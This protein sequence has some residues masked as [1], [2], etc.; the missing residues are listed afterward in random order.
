MEYLYRYSVEIN[1]HTHRF[2]SKKPNQK[3]AVFEFMNGWQLWKSSSS[4][5]HLKNDRDW[6]I[7][8]R[9]KANPNAAENFALVPVEYHPR[10]E[11]LFLWPSVWVGYKEWDVPDG[12]TKDWLSGDFSNYRIVDT[13]LWTVPMWEKLK[14]GVTNP[15]TL[16]ILQAFLDKDH[17]HEQLSSIYPVCKECY[18]P[19]KDWL[20]HPVVK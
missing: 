3:W 13:S 17:Q 7:G 19:K 5:Y 12:L 9:V 8:Q 4:K 1:G 10:Q 14:Y 16:S 6:V 20:T 15:I 11:A 2:T 18:L